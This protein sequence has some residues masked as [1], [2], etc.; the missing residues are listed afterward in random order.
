MFNTIVTIILTLLI[1][2]HLPIAYFASKELNDYPVWNKNKKIKW[3]FI[4]WL[5]PIIGS[6]VVQK[7]IHLECSGSETT[8]GTMLDP[9]TSGYGDCGGSGDDGGCI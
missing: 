4:V 7:K 1:V 6:V 8:G 2:F 5:L 3:L 9:G